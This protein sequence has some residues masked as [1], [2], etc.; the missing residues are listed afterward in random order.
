MHLSSLKPELKLCLELP[1]VSLHRAKLQQLWRLLV[2]MVS[3]AVDFSFHLRPAAG[4]GHGAGG[5]SCSL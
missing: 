3:R 4:A 1:R 5:E 2:V